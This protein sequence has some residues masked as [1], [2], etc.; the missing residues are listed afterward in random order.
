VH[1]EIECTPLRLDGREGRVDGGGLGDVAMADHDP[2]DAF[3]EGPDPL[4][5]CLALIGK[6]KLAALHVAG[7]GDAPGDRPIIGDPH[8]EAALPMHKTG[9]FGHAFFPP[10]G[11]RLSRMA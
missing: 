3:G 1:D 8:D 11:H 7:L 4:L 2:A 5:Q 10:P 6:G 9:G